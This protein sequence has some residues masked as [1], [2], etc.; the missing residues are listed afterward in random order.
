MKNV[1]SF[2]DEIVLDMTSIPAYKEHPYNLITGT[3]DNF[4]RAAAIYGANASGKSNLYNGIQ[5]FQKIVVSSMNTVAATEDNILKNI[6]IHLLLKITMNH[7]NTR[8]F[9]AILNG[10]I[11]T[12]L[13]SMMKKS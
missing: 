9:S 6:L 3:N 13:N 11:H 4:V 10:N 1:L 5:L 8:L 12:V 7:Q 2:K